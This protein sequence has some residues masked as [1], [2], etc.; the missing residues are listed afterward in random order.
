SRVKYC[1]VKNELKTNEHA[2]AVYYKNIIHF[3]TSQDL[4][5]NLLDRAKNYQ[6][7]KN[8]FNFKDLFNFGNFR[9]GKK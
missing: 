2:E 3:F 6:E 5:F 7:R 4:I 8:R 9:K 1:R